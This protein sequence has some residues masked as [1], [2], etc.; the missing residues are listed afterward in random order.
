[1]KLLLDTHAFLWYVWGAPELSASAAA[2]IDDPNNEKFLSVASLWELAIKV[3]T[4]KLVLN[5]PFANLKSELIDANGF[6]VLAVEFDHTVLVSSLPFHHKDPF[7]RI[8]AAQ[9]L[10]ETC[11]SSVRTRSSMRTE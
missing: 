11:P 1:M 5:R 4:G 2:L 3:S 8:L 6:D 7:D 9:S 10:E